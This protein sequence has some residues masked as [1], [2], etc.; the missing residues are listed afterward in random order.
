M[1]VITL[2]IFVSITQICLRENCTLCPHIPIPLL[3]SPTY[4][5]TPY[6][7]KCLARKLY[8]F[9]QNDYINCKKKIPRG[10]KILLFF[11]LASN[12]DMVNR[13]LT[14]ISEPVTSLKI[15]NTCKVWQNRNIKMSWV[16]N[17]HG[18]AK[19]SLSG[20]FLDFCNVRERYVSL[21]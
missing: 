17:D 10:L 2:L 3:F 9:H 21:I 7:T 19:Q 15:E 8:S 11:H 4:F 1:T 20:L 6:T 16:T 14:A 13:V 5:T 12:E 18:Y